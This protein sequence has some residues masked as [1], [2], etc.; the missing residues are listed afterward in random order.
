MIKT[1]KQTENL[2]NQA[3]GQLQAGSSVTDVAL[4]FNVQR[5]TIYALQRRYHAT[6]STQDGVRSGRPRVTTA[7]Q[8]RFVISTFDTRCFHL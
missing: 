1:N 6:G 5:N 3:L 4:H 7:A 2:Q 8:D